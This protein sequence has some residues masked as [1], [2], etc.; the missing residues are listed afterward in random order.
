MR[1]LLR[2]HAATLTICSGIALTF[3]IT[4]CG[5]DDPAPATVE[6]SDAA[7]PVVEQED[8]DEAARA[9]V[10][11]LATNDLVTLRK[12]Q[13]AVAGGSLAE[14]Y[15]RHQAN[16]AESNLDGGYPSTESGEL[17]EGDGDV[18]RACF[19]NEDRSETNCYDYADFK[20]N[21]AGELV[22]FSIDGKKLKGRLSVGD[23]TPTVTPLGSFVFDTAYITQSG[24]LSVSG[25]IKTKH[26]K[27]F[28]EAGS[29]YRSPNGR[30][31]AMSSSAGLSEFPANS[32]STFTA[33]FDGPIKFGGE[34][35]LTFVEDGG[36]YSQAVAT[37]KIK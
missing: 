1:S 27:V 33:Y 36:S 3:A 32:R 14:A 19:E 28:I 15:M 2:K 10:E 22:D 23:G 18:L 29:N 11:A 6:A 25:T 4:S 34:M 12:Q 9:Y 26:A 37:V 5:S 31:R 35:N 24:A 7:A 30:V 20:V 13:R 21:E 17:T 8:V 16:G